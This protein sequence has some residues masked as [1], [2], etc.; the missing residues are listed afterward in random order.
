MTDLPLTT[1][2]TLKASKILVIKIGSVLIRGEGLDEVNAPWMDA[3]AEDVAKLM[4][5]GTK[6]VI[7]SSGGVALGRK[8]LGIAHDVAP[9]KI[10]LEQK[11]AASAVGQY[12]MF[13]GY[14]K[15]F[16]KQ[17]ITAAQVLLTM[18]E[19]E[20][21]RMNLNA[22]E[23]LYTL[24]DKGIVPVIN[25]NDTVSTGEIRFGD[26]D[27]LSVR[28]A[29]MIQAD[30]VLLLSTTDG[31]YTENPDT[32]ENAIHFPVIKKITEEHVQMAGDAIPGLST[33]G[34]KSK[35]EA[36][37]SA[38]LTAINLIIAKG[39]DNH[40]LKDLIENTDRKSTL[41]LA[42]K[43][44]VNAR[45]KW[46][47][48]HMRPKGT[49]IIDDGA[50]TALKKGKSLLPVG[51]KEVEGHFQRGDAVKIQTLSGQ[52][53][54]MGFSAYDVSEAKQIIGKNSSE[55]SEILGYAGRNELVHR[56]D[57]VL[58]DI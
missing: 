10:R 46:L 27:R 49:L 50:L 13:N 7:V 34:M 2:N 11:Q 38:T 47:Q 52:K 41:F 25:E 43:S 4:Q 18:S 44:D 32:N 28:V 24:L 22:R 29:Q 40:A 33:G 48:S 6:V 31:L 8:A 16:Q 19:T 21:R 51:I 35:I 56:N 42:Q 14:F 57:M 58:E 55:I 30:T 36:A 1:K 3:L 26:N 45:K 20:N 54:G 37:Q 53:I 39:T 15:A 17:N 5:N 9:T 12:H 23:T